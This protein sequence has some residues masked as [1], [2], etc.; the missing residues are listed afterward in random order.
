MRVSHQI[1]PDLYTCTDGSS[2]EE[3]VASG[4]EESAE[5][6]EEVAELQME[7][8]GGWGGGRR[9]R[10]RSGRGGGETGI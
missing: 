3:G 7:G 10:A 9:G 4:A 8:R 5:L 1:F 6:Q 2:E